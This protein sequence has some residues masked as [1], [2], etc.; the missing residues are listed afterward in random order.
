MAQLSVD[1]RFRHGSGFEID[2]KLDAG[3]GVTALFGPSGSGKSTLLHLIAGVLQPS[4][5]FIRL[6]DRTLVDTKANFALAPERRLVGIVFQ[7]HLLFPHMTV[8]KNLRFGMDRYGGRSV[9]FDKVVEI[10]EIGE[11]LDRL[12]ATLSGGQRQRVA[13]GRAL[14]RGP[15]LLLLDEP[16]ASLHHSLKDRILAYLRPM[17]QEWRIPTLFVCHD[18]Q[19]VDVFSDQVV[20]IQS[21]RVRVITPLA[22][23]DPP[24]PTG[25]SKDHP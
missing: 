16:L 18:K 2:A 8:R 24:T 25:N 22:H 12:P 19:D 4:D 21:G 1:V 17:F 11:L 3:D 6:G 7:D 15:E 20:S 10:L 5:G 9:S 23:S 14:L 13:L